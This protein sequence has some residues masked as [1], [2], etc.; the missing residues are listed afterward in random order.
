MAHELNNPLGAIN[1]NI[2]ILKRREK[3]REYQEVLESIRKDVLR[4]NRIVSN[5]LSFSRSKSI[6]T[7]RVSLAEV[8]DASLELFQVVIERRRI[9]VRRSYAASLPTIWGNAQDLQ[10]VFV[11]LIA[12]AVDAMP[13]GG[14]IDISAGL[15]E[16]PR[17]KAAAP[18]VAVV[19]DSAGN[20]DFLRSLV[21]VPGWEARFFRGDEE[22]IDFFR[23]SQAQLPDVL[24]LDYADTNPDRVEFFALMVRECAPAAKIL[25]ISG[26]EGADE[27]LS[28]MPGIAGILP[29]PLVAGQVIEQIRS[30]L[31]G[32]RAAG[33]ARADIV[34]RFGDTGA[35]IPPD[36]MERIF[37]PFFT[38][39][40]TR[41]TG[42]GLSVVHKILD[43]H[44][45]SIGVDS[46]P[47]RG[48][49]FTMVFPQSQG[50]GPGLPFRMEMNMDSGRTIS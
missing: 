17:A 26:P 11:N 30:L 12:N 25:V 22:A 3:D 34:V 48:T 43:N 20:L 35:G 15:E 19:Y 4:I 27:R 29:R 39:K 23:Q 32:A 16:A 41:G 31:A 37:D 28:R 49:T 2:E 24:L 50:G 21:S 44:G 38:T 6:S 5:L 40:E 10:Q 7:G 18:G 1:F 13:S 42:L 36:V 46:V 8:L 14:T 33:P 45:A 47:G 9:E